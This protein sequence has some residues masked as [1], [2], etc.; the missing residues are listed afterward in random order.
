MGGFNTFLINLDECVCKNGKGCAALS[1]CFKI[2]DRSTPPPTHKK[3]KKKR[4]E[5]FQSKIKLG[6]RV[7]LFYPG[8]RRKRR[9]REEVKS[10]EKRPPPPPVCARPQDHHHYPNR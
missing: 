10:Q 1:V 9:L 5:C 8:G 6:A 2:F 4:H 7:I 3:R